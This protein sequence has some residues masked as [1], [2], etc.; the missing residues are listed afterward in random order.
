MFWLKNGLIA[1]KTSQ[2]FLE[3][4]A[5]LYNAD[6]QLFTLMRFFATSCIIY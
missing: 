3:N 2:C 1:T 6:N 5:P 4:E